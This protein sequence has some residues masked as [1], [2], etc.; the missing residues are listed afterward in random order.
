VTTSDQTEEDFQDYLDNRLG[1]RRRAEVAAYLSRNPGKASEIEALR[2]QD[3]ALRALGAEILEEPVPQR[4]S[5][6]LHSAGDT[7]QVDPHLAARAHWHPSRLVEIAAALFIFVLGGAV[8]WGGHSQLKAGPS[9]I[10]MIL[11]NASYAY[12][13]FA[14]EENGFLSLGPDQS[15]ELEQ[16]SARIFKRSI[17]HPDLSNLGL[18]Y[19]GARILPNER[20]MVGYFLFQ[21][22]NGARVSITI[23]PNTLP[24]NPN[25][26]SSQMDDVQA[27]FWLEDDLGF[28]VMGGLDD[29]RLDEVTEEVF[30]YYKVPQAE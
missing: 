26:I 30:T 11:A 18:S 24:P 6:V 29:E 1:D 27:R 10:D 8:G 25:I 23:W 13:S 12:A 4:L 22:E 19:Q 7:P 5:A 3:D 16:I 2:L 20:R 21:D 14:D 9:E 15:S 28:A 17:A